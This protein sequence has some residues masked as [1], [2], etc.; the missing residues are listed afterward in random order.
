M[1]RLDRR[2]RPSLAPALAML[3]AVAPAC[4]ATAGHHPPGVQDPAAAAGRRIA[5]RPAY[6]R[7]FQPKTLYLNTYAA[8]PYPPV[9]NPTI[10]RARAGRLAAPAPYCPTSGW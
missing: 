6:A 8:D 1:S 4:S 5:M 7:L 3:L 2:R 10:F 9:L